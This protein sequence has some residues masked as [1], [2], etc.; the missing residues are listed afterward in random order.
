MGSSPVARACHERGG[1]WV[2]RYDFGTGAGGHSFAWEWDGLIGGNVPLKTHFPN[3]LLFS[4]LT[5]GRF[6]GRGGGMGQ[7]RASSCFREMRSHLGVLAGCAFHPN[8]SRRH[9]S[10]TDG[11]KRLVLSFWWNGIL[12]NENECVRF[13]DK[14]LLLFFLTKQC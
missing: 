5:F 2:Q 8:N 14:S 1:G 13:E 11:F 6:E 3:P 9:P 10:R 12:R 4:T 7:E